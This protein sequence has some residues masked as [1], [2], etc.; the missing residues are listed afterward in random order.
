MF[1]LLLL[2]TFTFSGNG[3]KQIHKVERIEAKSM[4]STVFDYEYKE[5][6]GKKM[7]FQD[8]LSKFREVFN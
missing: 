7:I 6:R 5:D 8:S 2:S 1:T 4:A 3:S